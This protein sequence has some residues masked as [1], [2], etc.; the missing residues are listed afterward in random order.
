MNKA[1]WGLRVNRGKIEKGGISFL[2]GP[3]ESIFGRHAGS[4]GG[5]ASA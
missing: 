1:I 4:G 3:A 5:K 2:E